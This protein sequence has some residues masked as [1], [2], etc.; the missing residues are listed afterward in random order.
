[1]WGGRR[2]ASG[3]GPTPFHTPH[4]RLYHTIKVTKDFII[5]EA[6]NAIAFCRDHGIANRIAGVVG[7]TAVLTSIKLD[8][9]LRPVFCEIGKISAYWDLPPEMEPVAVCLS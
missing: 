4:N 3:G 6:Q 7:V 5:C 1:M 2:E 8:D 9:D